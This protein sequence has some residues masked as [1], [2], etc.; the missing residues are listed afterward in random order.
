MC[1][2]DYRDLE[3]YNFGGSEPRENDPLDH[4]IFHDPDF[5]EAVRVLQ[6]DL[7]IHSIE[8][9]TTTTQ[10]DPLRPTIHFTGTSKGGTPNESVVYGDV[11]ITCTGDIRWQLISNYDGE[12]RWM[13]SGLQAGGTG[14]AIGVLG[15][16]SSVDHEPRDPA[17][18]FW[19][20]RD[21]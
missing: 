17:G 18:P 3:M 20:W 15:C 14:S 7:R 9:P 5:T 13:S 2:V 6:L 8:D 19:L 10:V 16:W 11:S 1:F 21:S 12:D 4:S